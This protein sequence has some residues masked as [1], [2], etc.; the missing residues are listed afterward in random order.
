MWPLNTGD[1]LKEVTSWADL[2]VLKQFNKTENIVFCSVRTD[3]RGYP[4]KLNVFF[5]NQNRRNFTSQKLPVIRNCS[6]FSVTTAFFFPSVIL[7]PYKKIHRQGFYIILFFGNRRTLLKV[8]TFWVFKNLITFVRLCWIFFEQ[9]PSIA[10]QLKKWI[11]GMNIL[12]S[13]QWTFL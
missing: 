3:A 6:F 13:S 4:Q 8:T 11:S 5:L 10:I 12:T 1:C 7:N 9:V 2:T